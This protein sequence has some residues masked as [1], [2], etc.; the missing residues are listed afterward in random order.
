MDWR[1]ILTEK[2]YFLELLEHLLADGQ[3]ARVRLGGSTVGQALPGDPYVCVQDKARLSIMLEGRM[4]YTICSQRQRR[5]IELT[6]NDAIYW[7]RHAWSLDHWDEP[8]A[9][10]GI[11][12]TRHFTRFLVVDHP[13]GPK[14]ATSTPWFYHTA[15][16]ISEA[17]AHATWALDALA[18]QG[19]SEAT[20][21]LFI[22]L[23]HLAR[24]HL[25]GDEPSG[26]EYSASATW[27]R[28]QDY[29]HENYALPISRA[30]VARALCLHPN[31]LS[32]LC[33][34][35]GGVSFH[36]ALEAI[37]IE[38]AQRLLKQGD[39]DVAR[40]AQ[41]CGFSDAPHL[42]RAFRRAT[43]TTPHRHRND[44]LR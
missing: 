27:R 26:E 8:Y 33:A 20:R 16:P 42:T 43:G 41:L 35:E 29:L 7:A 36:Q 32:A 4:K 38:R 14:P 5:E 17:G 44:L 3:P 18:D 15:H 12:F 2:S 21:P 9:F 6:P 11:V 22:T 25:Q 24:E 31:Y 39:L 28:V 10:F 13:G 40:I 34:R 37:R 30:S 19:D 23:L 1:P